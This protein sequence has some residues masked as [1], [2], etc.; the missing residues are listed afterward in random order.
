MPDGQWNYDHVCDGWWYHGHIQ[1]KVEYLA[2]PGEVFFQA[3]CNTAKSPTDFAIASSRG[4]I[5]LDHYHEEEYIGLVAAATWVHKK[6]DSDT[7]SVE[8]LTPDIVLGGS[9][10][11]NIVLGDVRCQKA[12]YRLKHPSSVLHLRRVDNER[13][14]AVGLM[15][16]VRSSTL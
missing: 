11:G 5:V 9:R 7:L 15:N 16:S 1:S 8:W 4:L 10:D 12:V 6:K 3:R 13:I 2:Q 14:V